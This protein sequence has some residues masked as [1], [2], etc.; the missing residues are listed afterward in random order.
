M[1]FRGD[2][3]SMMMTYLPISDHSNQDLYW[4]E[5]M[6]SPNLCFVR[7][8]KKDVYLINDINILM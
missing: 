6:P 8:G 7:I 2:E 5:F 1:T 4:L 3:N